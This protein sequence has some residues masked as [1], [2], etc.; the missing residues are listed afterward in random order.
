M[1]KSLPERTSLLHFPNCSV[2][3]QRGEACQHHHRNYRLLKCHHWYHCLQCHHGITMFFNFLT[4][5]LRRG[6][7][8][9]IP[10]SSTLILSSLLFR[11]F[12]RIYSVLI[13]WSNLVAIMFYVPIHHQKDNHEKEHLVISSPFPPQYIIGPSLAMATSSAADPPVLNA[14]T[15]CPDFLQKRWWWT[16]GGRLMLEICVAWNAFTLVLHSDY[17]YVNSDNNFVFRS[18]ILAKCKKWQKI[19]H[20]IDWLLPIDNWL[21]I[22]F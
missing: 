19:D 7:N 1:K 17:Q 14:L 9:V 6:S 11:Y 8:W 15:S 5:H 2:V 13:N 21:S 22:Y 20:L 18:N 4:S 12:Q 10:D 16:I 3:L